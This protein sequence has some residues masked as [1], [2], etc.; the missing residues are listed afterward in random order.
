MVPYLSQRVGDRAWKVSAE[1]A[2][3]K[4]KAK[5]IAYAYCAELP[6]AP[7]VVAKDA[8]VEILSIESISASCAQGSEAISGGFDIATRRGYSAGASVHS[9]RRKAGGRTWKVSLINGG[10]D[11]HGRVFAYCLPSAG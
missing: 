8:P 7:K 1:N 5:L 6:E 2:A 10:R 3:F 11:R 9:S 4:G